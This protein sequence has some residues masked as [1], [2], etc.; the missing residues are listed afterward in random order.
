MLYCICINH[1]SEATQ[2]S[3]D[4]SPVILALTTIL[5]AV[6]IKNFVG[7]FGNYYREIC[8]FTGIPQLVRCGQDQTFIIHEKIFYT[9]FF[10]FENL[11]LDLAMAKITISK[12]LY[13]FK[14]FDTMGIK[15]WMQ[16]I[17]LICWSLF[18]VVIMLTNHWYCHNMISISKVRYS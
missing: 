2:H 1:E 9:W 11:S 14:D 6:D 13:C 8:I 10:A 17:S 5:C 3:L 15:F 4:I 12:K 7:V 18:K 16:I